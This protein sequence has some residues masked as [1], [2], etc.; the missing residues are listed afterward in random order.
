MMDEGRRLPRAGVVGLGV[1]VHARIEE[2]GL[3]WAE[4]RFGLLSKG[5]EVQV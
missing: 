3:G 5:F 1:T 2:N 4:L